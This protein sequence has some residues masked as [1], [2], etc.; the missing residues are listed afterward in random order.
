MIRLKI[1]FSCWRCIARIF[2]M[3][4]NTGTRGRVFNCSNIWWSGRD[5]LSR[6][7][8]DGSVNLVHETGIVSSLMNDFR[9]R[10]YLNRIVVGERNCRWGTVRTEEEAGKPSKYSEQNWIYARTSKHDIY[11]VDLTSHD[12]ARRQCHW[13]SYNFRWRR[14]TGQEAEITSFFP[15]LK[16]TTYHHI[17]LTSAM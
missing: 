11:N 3:I 15:T 12:Q 8:L 17:H 5:L 6:L 9:S 10:R 4:H 2:L 1:F 7:L 13:A 14:R 16:L